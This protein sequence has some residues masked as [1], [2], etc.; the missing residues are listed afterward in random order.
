MRDYESAH[1]L[2]KAAMNRVIYAA[3]ILFAYFV[4]LAFRT[5]GRQL[6]S[7]PIYYFLMP[8]MEAAM[9]CYRS[10]DLMPPDIP[11]AIPNIGFAK[12][13]YEMT[14]HFFLPSPVSNKRIYRIFRAFLGTFW[15]L[16]V[17]AYVVTLLPL[18]AIEWAYCTIDRRYHPITTTES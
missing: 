18:I 4:L 14:R 9:L 5:M 13:M 2:V 17:G 8:A 10:A 6:G 3:I 16:I 11:S 12:G 15:G 1:Y 7:A